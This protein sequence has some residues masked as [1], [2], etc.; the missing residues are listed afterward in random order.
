ML[1]STTSFLIN[2]RHF[3]PCYFQVV[4]KLYIYNIYILDK[5]QLLEVVYASYPL[6]FLQMADGGWL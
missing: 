6:L 1:F 2:L 3:S 4:D 5:S